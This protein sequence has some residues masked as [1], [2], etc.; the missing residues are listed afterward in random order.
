MRRQV[1]ALLLLASSVSGAELAGRVLEQHSGAPLDR[2]HVRLLQP[3]GATEVETDAAGR[4]RFA[5]NPEG[6]FRIGVSREGYADGLLTGSPGAVADAV[7]RLAKTGVITGRVTNPQGS[8]IAD[9]RVI[10]LLNHRPL[11]AHESG[12]D[13]RGIYRLYGLPPGEYSVAALCPEIEPQLAGRAFL[14]T[15]GDEYRD[16]DFTLS[17]GQFQRVS[18]RVQYP[19]AASPLLLK[20]ASVEFPSFAVADALA[21]KDGS[22]VFEKVPPGAY[23]LLALGPSQ[24]NGG[25]GGFLGSNPVYGRARVDVHPGQDVKELDLATYPGATVSFVLG[26][27]CGKGATLELTSEEDWGSKTRRR[28]EVSVSTP[29]KLIDLAPARYHVTLTG[30]GSSCFYA[31]DPILDFTAGAPESFKLR[32]QPGASLHGQLTG[33]GQNQVGVILIQPEGDRAAFEAAMPDTSGSFALEALRPGKYRILTVPAAA[34]SKGPWTPAASRMTE[35]EL[36]PGRLT[37]L[38]LPVAHLP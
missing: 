31:G 18:G 14:I 15:S 19:D 23:H 35:V 29:G 1:G 13:D 25:Y 16:V 7:I 6:P 2:A 4:F 26:G 17:P 11:V 36:L 8:P 30:L 20:L 21:D 22:F 24:G 32:T 28:L 10:P 38:E 33:P 12:V 34:W 37:N 5:A 3:P 9:A 27:P